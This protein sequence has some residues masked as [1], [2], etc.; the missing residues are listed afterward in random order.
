[1]LV[2]LTGLHCAGKSYFTKN[3]PPKYGFKVYNKKEIVASLCRLENGGDGWQGWYKYEFNKD[4]YTMTAKII[5]TL[6]IDEDIVLDAVHSNVEWDIITQLVPDSVLAV[7]VSPDDVR[8]NRWTAEIDISKKDIKRIGFWHTDIENKECLIMK[9]G[10]SF[11]GTATLEENEQRFK[12]LIKLQSS[13]N[14]TFK[15]T[16]TNLNNNEDEKVFLDLLDENK[17]LTEE[18]LKRMPICGNCSIFKRNKI[19]SDFEL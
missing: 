6:P 3:V 16:T 17:K 18:L 2:A 8:K 11:D 12:D 14:N 9:I 1:M 4:P 7:F 13:K 15:D 19:E 10:W 5:N